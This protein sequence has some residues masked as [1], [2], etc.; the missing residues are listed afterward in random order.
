MTS[1]LKMTVFLA[2]LLLPVESCVR[3]T[4]V[5]ERRAGHHIGRIVQIRR[6]DFHRARLRQLADLFRAEVSGRYVTG[7][8]WIVTSPADS[9]LVQGDRER[10]E[11]YAE[12]RREWMDQRQ[13]Q[14]PVA[15]VSVIGNDARLEYRYAEGDFAKEVLS[16]RDPFLVEDRGVS[17]EIAYLLATEIPPIVAPGFLNLPEYQL[18]LYSAAGAIPPLNDAVLKG[19][20]RRLKVRRMQVHL[21]RD[22]VIHY[23]GIPAVYPFARAV[24]PPVE[25]NEYR[26]FQWWCEVSEDDV[27]CESGH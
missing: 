5:L 3:E 10:S 2:V 1:L 25:R 22:N 23:P 6:A 11:V 19:F 16:E 21:R 7:T 18:F 12:W 9:E 17:Y 27:R 4:E 20:A 15:R 14:F 24:P 26:R 13:N 8:Q